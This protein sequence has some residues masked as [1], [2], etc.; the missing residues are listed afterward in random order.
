MENSYNIFYVQQKLSD[1]QEPLLQHCM[2]CLG[3]HAAQTQTPMDIKNKQKHFL[4]I[5][6]TEPNNFNYV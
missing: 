4:H 2:S 5:R 6:K 1:R 3:I